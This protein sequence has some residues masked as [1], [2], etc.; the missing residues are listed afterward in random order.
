MMNSPKKNRRI[1]LLIRKE[2]R[3]LTSARMVLVPMIVVPLIMAVFLPVVMIVAVG[4]GGTDMINGVEQMTSLIPAYSFPEGMEDVNQK[5]LYLFLNYSFLPLFLVVPLMVSSIIAT[6][7]VVGEKERGTL[8]TL[9]YTPITNREFI[10]GKLAAA[11]LPGAF[12]APVA[13]LLYFTVSNIAS[14]ILFDRFLVGGIIWLPTLLLL[15]PA[16]SLLG[17]GVALLVSIKSTSFMEAQQLSAMVVI[18][19]IALM[20][21]QVSGVIVFNILYLVIIAAI[22]LLVDY[23]LIT[24]LMP[25]FDREAIIMTLGK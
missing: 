1:S 21:A 7:G 18:P 23:I 8:E 24:R 10:L 2:L 6:N 14:T 20:I 19:L 25:R 13:F 22:L 15:S 16:V 9:L 4:L 12:I 17:L 5:L 11:F 3:M